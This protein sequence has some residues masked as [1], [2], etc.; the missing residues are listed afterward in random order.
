MSKLFLC[1]FQFWETAYTIVSLKWKICKWLFG[2][3]NAQPLICLI[4]L[5]RRFMMNNTIMHLLYHFSLCFVLKKDWSP[6]LAWW[7]SRHVSES[8]W[9]RIPVPNITHFC[10]KIVLLLSE[11]DEAGLT[12]QLELTLFNNLTPQKSNWSHSAEVQRL[13]TILP[14]WTGSPKCACLKLLKKSS[15]LF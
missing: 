13:P 3:K 5:G 10:W 9:V 7:L 4:N 11:K 15:D 6:G 8:L 1:R 12:L 2:F 14:K